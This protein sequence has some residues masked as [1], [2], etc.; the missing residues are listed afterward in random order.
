MVDTAKTV[1]GRQLKVKRLWQWRHKQYKGLFAQPHLFKQQEEAPGFVAVS[2]CAKLGQSVRTT[3]T[4]S[5]A[6]PSG[7]A[8]SDTDSDVEMRD[9]DV[10]LLVR[11]EEEEESEEEEGG[12]D[13]NGAWALRA[14]AA[15]VLDSESEFSLG[16]SSR[17]GADED[18][19]DTGSSGDS[20]SDLGD[21]VDD[22]G[23]GVIRPAKR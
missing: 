6:A 14:T 16:G 15:I 23:F 2:Q 10:L 5:D 13:S 22:D 9:S 8:E 4:T 11:D 1:F 18:E 3:G 12:R 17:S 19:D 20:E 7:R 21:A